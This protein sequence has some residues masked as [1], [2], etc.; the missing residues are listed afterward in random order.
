MQSFISGDVPPFVTPQDGRRPT[1]EIGGLQRGV[2]RSSFDSDRKE[3]ISWIRDMSQRRDMRRHTTG[4]D[5]N[6]HYNSDYSFSVWERADTPCY[7]EGDPREEEVEE[8]SIPHEK[9]EVV[10]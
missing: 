4:D 3:K 2:D 8:S 5:S 7:Q 10:P 1:S 9:M 6:E